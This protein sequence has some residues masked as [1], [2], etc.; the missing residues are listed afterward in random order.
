VDQAPAT[1]ETTVITEPTPTTAEI[2][3]TPQVVGPP[4]APLSSAQDIRLAIEQAHG[5]TTDVAAQVNRFGSFPAIPTPTGASIVELRADARA[6][7]DANTV[8]VTSEVALEADGSRAALSDFYQRQLGLLG[9][10]LTDRSS[11]DP[12]SGP[13]RLAFEIPGTPY[14]LD[15]VEV[16]LIDHPSK[17]D[18]TAVRLLYVELASVGDTSVRQRFEGWATGVPLPPG[19]EITGAGIQTIGEGR[20]SLYFSL[21]LYYPDLDPMQVA[22]GVR[23]GLPTPGFALDP[24]APT[25]DALDNWVFLTSPLFSNAQ[26]STHGKLAGLVL[27][28]PTVVNL[29]GRIDFAPR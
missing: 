4:L 25:G 19:G 27:V 24:K 22:A 13:I 10:R 23:A 11:L 20:H 2:S 15:D 8:T 1:I 12:L 7:V 6:T 16:T 9:W 28:A 14:Q 17:A 29:A 3:T 18:H 21:T 26:V 5:P